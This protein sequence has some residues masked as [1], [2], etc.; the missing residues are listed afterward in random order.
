MN[1]SNENLRIPHK[2]FIEMLHNLPTSHSNS[3][4]LQRYVVVESPLAW[5]PP[6]NQVLD[7]M[8]I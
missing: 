5:H 4:L 8:N 2:V 3:S 7:L 1:Q 6:K